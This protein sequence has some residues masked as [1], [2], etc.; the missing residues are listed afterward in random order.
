VRLGMVWAAAA[1]EVLIVAPIIGVRVN[2]S[3]A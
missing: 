3:M 2:I 1:V